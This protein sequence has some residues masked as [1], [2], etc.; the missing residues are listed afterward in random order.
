MSRSKA[1]Q[2]RRRFERLQTEQAKA[3]SIRT[4]TGGFFAFI[5][6]SFVEPD[7]MLIPTVQ[8]SGQYSD[9]TIT[10]KGRKLGQDEALHLRMVDGRWRIVDPPAPGNASYQRAKRRKQMRRK[11]Q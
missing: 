1:N 9:H 11:Q 5:V 4:V 7:D 6:P 10:Y 8:P 2:R 3:N